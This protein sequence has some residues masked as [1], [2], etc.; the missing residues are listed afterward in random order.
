MNIM[1]YA[2]K[3]ELDG[4][5][6]YR[7]QAEK[8]R[9]GSVYPLLVSMADQEKKHA[10]IIKSKYEGR[11]YAL[12]E[13]DSLLKA[14]GVFFDT[15]DI[16]AFV[17]E[18]PEQVDFYRQAAEKEFESIALY[19]KMLAG[20]GNEDDKKFCRFLIRE[21]MEHYATLDQLAMML[22]HARSWVEAAEFGVRL[23]EY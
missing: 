22:E 2:V 8:N 18:S 1:E 19:Q 17:M 4:E 21:E 11:Q 3:M 14:K 23:E 12:A 13:D 9:G 16:R 6:Y 15:A 7:S 5:Q 10:Q 20:A